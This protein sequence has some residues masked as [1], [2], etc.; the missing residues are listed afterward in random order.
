MTTIRR[1]ITALA[2]FAF[3]LGYLAQSALAQR[4]PDGPSGP[5]A[6]PPPVNPPASDGSPIWQFALVAA[7]AVVVTLLLTVAVNAVR[8][9]RWTGSKIAHA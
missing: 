4:A 2:G 8:H 6:P 5:L 3:A 1:L 7:A 9:H